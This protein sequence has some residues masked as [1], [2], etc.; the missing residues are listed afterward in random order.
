MMLPGYR[1]TQPQ[2]QKEHELQAYKQ[3]TASKKFQENS[4]CH[5]A[6]LYPS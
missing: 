4:R 5:K 2:D 3:A 6:K 1:K